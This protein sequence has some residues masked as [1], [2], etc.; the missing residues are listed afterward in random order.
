MAD[1]VPVTAD[2]FPR[3]ETDMYFARFSQ[4]KVG[5]LIHRRDPANADNQTVVR[6]NPNVL[7]SLGVF[8]LDAG[9][10]TFTLPDAGERFVSLMVTDE[11]HYTYTTYDSGEHTLAREKIGTRYVFVAVRILVDPTDADDVAAV[12]ALQDAMVVDQPGGPGTFEVPEWDSESQGKVRDALIALGDTLQ[13]S[14]RMFGTREQVEP[15]R[16]LIGTATGW[17]GNNEHDAFYAFSVPVQNDG[18][19]VYAVTFRDLPID[20]WWG[21]SVYNAEGYFEK[22]DRD[23]Y[24]INSVNAAANEDGS[25]TVTFGGCESDAPNCLPIFPGWNYAIR[26]Y[27]PRREVID[28][29]WTFPAAQP[30]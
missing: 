20:S 26:L 28:G 3:A 13:G 6:D 29:I 19:T 18:D 5:V 22:N 27:K 7:A 16:H 1:R 30:Q 24:T 12:H 23:I 8:D 2:N 21:V 9:P 11:D 25:F 4:G 14:N 15:V 17:G 10:V